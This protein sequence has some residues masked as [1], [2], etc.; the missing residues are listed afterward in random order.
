M[1]DS[2]IT[3]AA[4]L[5]QEQAAAYTRLDAACVHLAAALVRGVPEQIESLTRAGESELLR[6]RS[7]LFE[8]TMTLSLFAD[9]RAAANEANRSASVTPEART[10]FE[11]ASAELLAAAH[12]FERT[13]A[14]TAAIAVSGS[15][16]A[17]AC[18][19][20]C[21]VPPMTYRAP[22][23]RRDNFQGDR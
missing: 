11:S 22:Y 10:A 15:T 9:K 17:A 3:R 2:L 18:L 14:R 19:E 5:M 1:P 23:T 6:M 13:Q 21:G 16:F 8:I 7:R 12:A 20:T 4:A